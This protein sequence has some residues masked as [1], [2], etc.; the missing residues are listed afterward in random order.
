MKRNAT[1]RRRNEADFTDEEKRL[2]AEGKIRLPK[3]KLNLRKLDRMPTGTVK[4]NRA[5][6]AVLEDRE[7]SKY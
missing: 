4:G 3:V 1:R 7:E 2:E 6:R 5:V